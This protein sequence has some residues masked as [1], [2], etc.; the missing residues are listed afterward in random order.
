MVLNKVGLSFMA[1]TLLSIVSVMIGA[2]GITY[3]AITSE[4]TV[5]L[6]NIFIASVDEAQGFS[7]TAGPGLFLTFVVMVALLT[8]VISLISIRFGSV[9]GR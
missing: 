7:V 8:A 5:A 6:G 9:G 4:S 1:A 2:L 3:Y